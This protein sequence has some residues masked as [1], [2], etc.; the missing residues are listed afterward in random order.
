MTDSKSRATKFYFAK[1]PTKIRLRR[2][3]DSISVFDGL[4]WEESANLLSIRAEG[5]D[6]KQ[7]WKLTAGKDQ[8]GNKGNK[9]PTRKRINK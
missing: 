1:A 8:P 3:H 5:E 9:F 4:S 6:N 7:W 2:K